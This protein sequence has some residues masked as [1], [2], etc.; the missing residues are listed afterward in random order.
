M[1]GVLALGGSA[2]QSASGA[3]NKPAGAMLPDRTLTCDLGHATNLD[4][5]K[6]QTDTDI[7]YDSRHVFGVHLPAVPARTTPPPD[8]TEPPE[9]VAKGTRIIA[10]PDGIAKDVIGPVVRVADLWPERVE[11]TLPISSYEVKL[12]IITDFD[13]PSGK[14][15]MFM[16]NAKDAATFNMDRIYGG[17]CMVTIAPPQKRQS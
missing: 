15:R 14:A 3:E 10:D 6:D 4:P 9:P 16:T 7:I 2:A 17:N 11:L 8:A 5:L 1:L 12:I 13:A